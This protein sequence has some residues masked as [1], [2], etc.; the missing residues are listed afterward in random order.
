MFN[1]LSKSI[2][3][4]INELLA[5]KDIKQKELAQELGVTDN[6]I[7]YYVSGK[8]LPKI[9]HLIAIADFFDVSVDYFLGRTDVITIDKDAQFVCEYTGLSEGVI[10][11][12]HNRNSVTNSRSFAETN[13][14]S[15]AINLLVEYDSTLL[16]NIF[17]E[18]NECNKQIWR[19]QVFQK[20]AASCIPFLPLDEE[21][22]SNIILLHQ[23]NQAQIQ[24]TKFKLQELIRPILEALITRETEDEDYQALYEYLVNYNDNDR[25]KFG[26]NVTH[27]KKTAKELKAELRSLRNRKFPSIHNHAP[28][29]STAELNDMIDEMDQ[30]MYYEA[31][32]PTYDS[33]DEENSPEKH[34]IETMLKI[35]ELLKSNSEKEDTNE[36]TETKE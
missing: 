21:R 8:R 26:T 16:T 12:L 24:F 10:E 35:N 36:H 31:E 2:G 14:V 29:Y 13:D 18:V 7:S 11:V 9:E 4:R 30:E 15:H 5:I 6:T 3:I 22:E 19:K 28:S 33:N 1:T 17:D 23:N 34:E 20:I 27:G 32:D 25:K